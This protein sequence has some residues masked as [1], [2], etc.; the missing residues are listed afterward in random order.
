MGRLKRWVRSRFSSVEISEAH[1]VRTLHLGGDAIQSAIRLSNPEALELHYTR[2]MM[3]FLLLVPEPRDVMMIGL[4]GGSI[5]RFMR[6]HY[7]RVH[8]RAVEINPSVIA[9]ARAWF[10]LP[11]DDDRLQVI[12]AD[13]AA[14]IGE[15]PDSCDVL[16]LDAFE[17]G[18]A[19]TALCSRGCYRECFAALRPGGALVQNFMSDDERLET[20]LGRLRRVFGAAVLELP[21]ANHVNTIVLALKGEMPVLQVESLARRAAAL[22]RRLGLPYRSMLRSLMQKN[23][24]IFSRSSTGAAPPRA[25]SRY[26]QAAS[27]RRS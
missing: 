16:M 7:P 1:G 13:G 23:D 26:G 10:G 14:Y 6:R 2:A 8:I 27:R 11:Q 24:V 9:A 20:C 15:H 5:A 18:E 21:A 3:G 17:D 19:V 22:E 4:G 25:S 12:A